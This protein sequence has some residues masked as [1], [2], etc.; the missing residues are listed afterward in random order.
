MV[1]EVALGGLL[2]VEQQAADSVGHASPPIV[3]ALPAGH[4]LMVSGDRYGDSWAA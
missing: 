4:S 2:G 1:Q 3:R